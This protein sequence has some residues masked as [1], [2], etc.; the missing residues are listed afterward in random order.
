MPSIRRG[1]VSEPSGAR[2]ASD[3]TRPEAV[4]RPHMRIGYQGEPHS[5][6][7][8]ATTEL[9]PDEEHLGHPSFVAA[10]VALERGEVDRLVLPVENST[11][12]S[13]L[14]VLDRLPGYGDHGPISIVAEHLVEVRHALLGLPGTSLEKIS[15]VK[16]HPEALA[17]AAETL[18]RL[19]I[20]PVPR[21]DT[22]GA[23]REV[24]EGGD[25]T[26]AALAPPEA[27]PPHG[28]VVLRSDVMDREH[29]TTRFVVLTKGN[30]EIGPE[31]DKTTLVFTTAHTPG[32]LALALTE[33]GLR[34]AN[35][36]RIESRPSDEAWAY[37]FFVDLVHPPGSQGLA[38]VIDPPPATLAHLRILGSY[39]AVQ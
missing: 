12:G 8:R 23:V 35:L 25:E 13:V 37:R 1:R 17:Q 21:R 2:E 16:S 39:R 24:A 14:P 28:L 20:R 6:S 3:G 36:T 4:Y 9:F 18:L 31:D 38:R 27:G 7:H 26:V 11:T 15:T 33:L 30:A 32:A 22:A 19:G 10:F 34:G 29:N 5:Y